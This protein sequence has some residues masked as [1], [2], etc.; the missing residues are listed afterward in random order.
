MDKNN[1]IVNIF[2][3]YEFHLIYLELNIDLP[4]VKEVLVL[5]VPPTFI[6]SEFVGFGIGL[7]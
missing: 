7:F 5:L 4:V 3:L 2:K 1:F 6:S